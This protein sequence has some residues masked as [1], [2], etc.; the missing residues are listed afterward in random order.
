MHVVT[1]NKAP[2]VLAYPRLLT[3]AHRHSVQLRFDATVA[4]GLPV[5][6]LGQRDLGVA[7]VLRLEG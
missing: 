4:G 7:R 2:L 3:L 1:A 5:I 6:N